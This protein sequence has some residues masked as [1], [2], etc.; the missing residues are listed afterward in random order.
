MVG[1]PLKMGYID[2]DSDNVKEQFNFVTVKSFLFSLILFLQ[3]LVK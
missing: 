1:W 3:N 2:D